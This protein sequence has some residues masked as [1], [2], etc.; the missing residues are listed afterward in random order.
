MMKCGRRFSLISSSIWPTNNERKF[1]RIKI[2]IILFAALHKANL[3]VLGCTKPC[4]FSSSPWFSN[5]SQRSSLLAWK[6]R[7][8]CSFRLCAWEGSSGGLWAL[9]CRHSLPTTLTFGYSARTARLATTVSHLACTPWSALQQ[10]SEALREW[11]VSHLDYKIDIIY[12]EQVRYTGFLSNLWL[13][14][15]N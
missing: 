2:I 11:Q 5:S 4:G 8:G 10:S 6:C 1:L 12:I 9:E 3:L 14:A 15:G 7:V 13:V